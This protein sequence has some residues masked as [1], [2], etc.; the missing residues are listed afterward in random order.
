MVFSPPDAYADQDVSKD[1]TE[2][3]LEKLNMSEE[4]LERLVEAQL[5]TLAISLS[6]V[7]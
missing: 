2:G 4:D 6:C 3:V 1:V 5:N 7:R